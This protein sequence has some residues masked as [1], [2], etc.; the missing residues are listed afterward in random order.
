M[1]K[2]IYLSMVLLFISCH[3]EES[4]K[5]EIDVTLHVKDN[6]TSPLVVTVE[7]NTRY[8]EEYLWTFEGGDPA[9]SSKR[10][11]GMVTFAAP[12]EHR[13]SLEAWNIAERDSKTFTVRV[14]SI[15]SADFDIQADINNYAPATF[16]INN[17]S[18]GGA[19]YL[20]LFDG[21]QPQTYEGKNPPAITYSSPGTY[22]VV[23]MADNGSALTTTSKQIEVRESLDASFTII[24]SFEDADDMEAPLRATFETQLQGVESLRWECEGASF[25]DAAFAGAVMLIPAAGTHTVYLEVSNGKETKRIFR[26]I[27]VKENCNLR[28]HKDIKLGISTAQSTVGPFYSTRLRQVIKSNEVNTAN[29]P[30][31]DI[32]YFGFDNTFSRNRFVSPDQLE[33]TTLVEFENASATR[34][35]NKQESGDIHLSVQEF[36]TMTTDAL[37]KTLQIKNVNNE[38]VYFEDIPLPRIVL[39]ETSDGR[40]GAIMVKQIVKAGKE[41]S[42]IV[43]DIKIQKND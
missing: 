32:A 18:S 30:L 42:Y 5:V 28:T 8:A 1:K 37:L 15:V 2:F 17:R 7:N 10:N 27:T 23:L 13:I 9:T 21:A 34:F 14:D 3:Q 24:P 22:T 20:W 43:A 11:P 31:I 35:I 41:D 6:H 40:K 16:L 19:S 33:T 26:Q 29:A 25:T 12:G 36:E 4:T 39:F 38:D